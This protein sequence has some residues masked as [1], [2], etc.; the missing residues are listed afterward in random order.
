MTRDG[1]TVTVICTSSHLTSF[2]VLVD[3]AGGQ[4]LCLSIYNLRSCRAF[5]VGIKLYMQRRKY[6]VLL[7]VQVCALRYFIPWILFWHPH[8]NVYT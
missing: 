8:F 4:V 2:A 6:T 5:C 7:I 3:V 1:D